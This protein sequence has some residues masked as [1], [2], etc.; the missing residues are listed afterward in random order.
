MLNCTDR[1]G[2]GGGRRGRELVVAE[3]KYQ[4]NQNLQPLTWVV[5][6]V[7]GISEFSNH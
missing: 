7:S 3:L 1:G 5:N 6:Q 4:W 2:G